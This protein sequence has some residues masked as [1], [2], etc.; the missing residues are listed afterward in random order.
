MR[1]PKP[2]GD[3]GGDSFGDRQSLP[4]F[5]ALRAF[6]AVGRLS[7]VRKAAV[8]LGVNHAVISRH[9]RLL[10][11]WLGVPLFDRSHVTPRLN[12][13]GREYHSVVSAS[14]ASI[15]RGTREVM[16]ADEENRLL[17]WCVPGMAS[18]WM[19]A[20]VED[21]LSLHSEIEVELRPTD[22]SPHFAADEA[23]A[24]IRFVRDIS[25]LATEA[26]VTWLRF[27]RPVVFPV[28]SPAW[29]AA[30]PPL[31]TPQDLLGVRLLHEENDDEWR[32]W[33][34]AKGVAPGER[35]PG[36]RLWHAHLTLDAARRGQG[37]SLANPF[38]IAD[39]LSQGRL[40]ALLPDD[41]TRGAEIGAY[42]LFTHEDAARRIPLIKFRDW[43]VSRAAAFQTGW[44]FAD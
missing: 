39:D 17:I 13:I 30:N 1:H 10:E 25:G 40:V 12:T 3:L 37:V 38:L 22:K 29:V 6:E 31:Q 24:D 43:L 32:A 15:S 2:D 28:A 9:L 20:N 5:A 23:D 33:L 21:F 11:T 26:G 4:P 44:R 8:E 34:L 19:A 36:P 27:A 7:G 18:R 41:R 42:V 16:R 35:L 14:I